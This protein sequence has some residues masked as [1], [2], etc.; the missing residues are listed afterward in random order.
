MLKFLDESHKDFSPK[1]E[2][3]KPNAKKVFFYDSV[4][5]QTLI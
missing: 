2:K 3:L 5:I 4:I 1:K